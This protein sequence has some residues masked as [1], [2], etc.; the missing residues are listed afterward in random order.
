MVHRT[1]WLLPC[2]AFVSSIACNSD[3]PRGAQGPQYGIKRVA[4]DAKIGRMFGGGDSVPEAIFVDY[5]T[6][7]TDL[8]AL[9]VEARQV[10]ER[11]SQV[12]L[13]NGDSLVVIQQSTPVGPSALGV[14]SGS[15]A[16][17]RMRPN[18]LWEQLQPR[19]SR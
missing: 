5:V 13:Q 11:I 14:V 8:P 2:L 12:A 6:P 19:Q 1:L 7:T 4:K 15:W 3:A 17:Y 10:L 16:A 9:D 18:G